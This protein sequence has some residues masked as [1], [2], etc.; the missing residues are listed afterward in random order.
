MAM[1]AK[2]RIN[3]AFFREHQSQEYSGDESK[4]GHSMGYTL[5]DCWIGSL[6]LLSHPSTLRFNR[7]T[8]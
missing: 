4:I 5:I 2:T 1:R 7:I 8:R 3:K 6:S